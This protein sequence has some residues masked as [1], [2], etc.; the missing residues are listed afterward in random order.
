MT[1]IETTPAHLIHV[2][3][4]QG[5]M[6]CF[7]LMQELRPHLTD[8]ATFTQQ[9]IRQQTQGYRLLAAK[10]DSKVVALAGYRLQENLIYGRFIY[11]DDLVTSPDLR[12][13]RLGEQLMD[14]IKAEVMRQHCAHLVLDTGLGNALAQRFYFR[15]GFLSKGMHFVR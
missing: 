7:S 9:V 5:L 10:Q 1:D 4:P 15:Q 6:Q 3:D 11:V 12:G 8:A 14:A 2:D 13:Q